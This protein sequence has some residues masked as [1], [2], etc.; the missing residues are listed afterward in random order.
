MR[1]RRAPVTIPT[2]RAGSGS[3]RW[4]GRRGLQTALVLMGAVATGTGTA[5]AVRGP[6]AIP[7]GAPTVASN[8]SVLRF[9]A[10]WWASQGPAF[11]RV[12]SRVPDSD[13]SLVA[14]STLTFLGGLAR[15]TAARTSG[16]PHP[17]FRVLT[18]LELVMP[19]L[20]ITWERH[21]RQSG[22][23]HEDNLRADR[24]GAATPT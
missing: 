8:D 20:L 19:P 18:V 6:A 11:G 21:L 15:L 24:P 13:G 3:R 2:A 23:A 7:G 1:G 5:V 9:Y 12:A 10:V 14:L 17:L 4:S 16:R 22:G